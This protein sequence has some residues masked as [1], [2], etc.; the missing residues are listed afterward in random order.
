MKKLPAV[1]VA[2]LLF[3]PCQATA[4]ENGTDASGNA[5]VVPITRTYSATSTGFCSGVLVAS[6]IVVTAKH[7]VLDSKGLVTKNVFVGK[8]GSSLASILP[9]DKV[10]SIETEN[11]AGPSSKNLSLTS[12][13]AFLI[14]SHDQ[15][16]MLPISLATDVEVESIRAAGGTLQGYGY[17]FYAD[18]G[19]SIPTFPKGYSGT[20]SS[21]IPTASNS[22]YMKSL[23]GNACIGDSGSPVLS[24]V[25]GRSI[26]IGILTGVNQSVNCTK[27]NS[28]GSYYALF[29]L[30]NKYQ[31]LALK[32]ITLADAY[33]SPIASAKRPSQSNRTIACR[34]GS[35]VKKVTAV[36]PK[37]P[38]GYL[39]S[40]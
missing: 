10:K 38:A 29:T 17:G 37:C 24:N 18:S 28:D 33:S 5:F 16:V 34:K 25:D 14:L 31:D 4:V 39:A 2:L 32:A 3:Q 30:V 13:I 19:G 9:T 6:K 11:Y 26:L 7:C 36:N 40:K 20:Y 15:K 27:L 1:L 21:R 23:P 12:D 8:A 22:G 35:I